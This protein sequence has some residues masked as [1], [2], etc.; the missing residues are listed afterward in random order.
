LYLL[1]CEF[2]STSTYICSITYIRILNEL[3]ILYVPW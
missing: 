3:F 2:V 1:T